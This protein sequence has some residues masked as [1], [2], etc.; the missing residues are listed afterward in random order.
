MERYG[1]SV[2]LKLVTLRTMRLM[3]VTALVAVTVIMPSADIQ[4]ID[5]GAASVTLL[6]V[7]L[8]LAL[9]LFWAWLTPPSIDRRQGW[10]ELRAL[11][12]LSITLGVAA[13]VW[14]V[15]LEDMTG[16]RWSPLTALLV[17]GAALTLVGIFG[18]LATRPTRHHEFR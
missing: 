1:R 4:R 17:G 18:L 15:F 14:I 11:G 6:P 5:W 8:W 9:A 13:S 10:R 16:I 7:L 3:T 12:L 2:G